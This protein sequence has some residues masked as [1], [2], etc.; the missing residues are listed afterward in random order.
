M[1]ARGGRR[2]FFSGLASGKL[3]LLWQIAVLLEATPNSL[4]HT[5]TSLEGG[6][7]GKRK[8]TTRIRRGT[9]KGAEGDQDQNALHI[10]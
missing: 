2:I 9:I 4:D 7:V 10:L 8:G 1:V 5:H 6:L 3:P